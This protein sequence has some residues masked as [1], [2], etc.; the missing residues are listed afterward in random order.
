MSWYI[1]VVHFMIA[2]LW[3][4]C[5]FF[6]VSELFAILQQID[7]V[8]LHRLHSWLHQQKDFNKWGKKRSLSTFGVNSWTFNKSFWSYSLDEHFYKLVS[9]E[10]CQDLSAAPF[11]GERLAIHT[12]VGQIREGSPSMGWEGAQ[13]GWD[14]RLNSQSKFLISF[15]LFHFCLSE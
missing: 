14:I 13:V 10:I 3:M 7:R 8:V 2:S 4:W 11:V 9:K 5:L 12:Q 15:F 1:N 6:A